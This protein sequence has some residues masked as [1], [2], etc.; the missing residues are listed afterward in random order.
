[1]RTNVQPYFFL[2]RSGKKFFAN[3]PRCFGVS[4]GSR[5]EHGYTEPLVITFRTDE[6]YIL[7]RLEREKRCGTLVNNN[8]GTCTL[9]LDVF[10]PNE[11]MHWAKSFIGRIIRIE[12]GSEAIR[13]KFNDDINRMYGMYCNETDDIQ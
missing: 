7:N 1:M 3:K 5:H 13:K 9:T 6:D 12:G 10:D 4:F 8:D 11:A 2:Y